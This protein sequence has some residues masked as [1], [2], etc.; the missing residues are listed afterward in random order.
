MR[1]W[2]PT[3]VLAALLGALLLQWRDWPPQ[4]TSTGSEPDPTMVDASAD[5]GQPDALIELRPPEPKEGFASMIERPLFRP[6]RRP[7]DLTDETSEPISE[8]SVV[9]S[10]DGMDLSAVIITPSLVAA[11][12]KDPSQPKVLRLRIGDD[13]AGW[14]VQDIL[15]DRLLLER[16]GE[17]NTLILRDYGPRTPIAE[18]PPPAP[19]P[20]RPPRGLPRA[21]AQQQ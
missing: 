5:P 1:R 9:T 21:D 19:I 4:P 7:E 10:L 3:L 16:Q 20:R 2:I 17:R 18:T 15:P 6:D 14:S 11:W 13:L 12:V 8:P